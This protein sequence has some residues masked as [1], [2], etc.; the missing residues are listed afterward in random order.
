[1][2]TV[3]KMEG[4]KYLIPT[5]PTLFCLFPSL[6]KDKNSNLIEKQM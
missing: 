5:R 3:Y 6:E 2:D 4:I 1:M